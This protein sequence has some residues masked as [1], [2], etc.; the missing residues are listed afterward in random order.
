[1]ILYTEEI[2]V[3][4]GG[5]YLIKTPSYRYFTSYIEGGRKNNIID[6]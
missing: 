3:L 1:M 6:N 4:V 2:Y 5:L